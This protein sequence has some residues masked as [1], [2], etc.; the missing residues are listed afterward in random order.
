MTGRRQAKAGE[1][2]TLSRELT[3]RNKLGIHARP[4]AHFVKTAAR[5]LSDI[6]VEKDDLKVSGKS[7]MGLLTLEG[8]QGAVLTVTADGP[9][10]EE[11]LEALQE[12][13]EKDTFFEE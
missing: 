8:Y 10:A 11:A 2:K 4:A 3:I 7:I 6:T 9:D 1:G 5:F 12:L 13:I